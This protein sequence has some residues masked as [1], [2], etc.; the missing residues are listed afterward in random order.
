MVF[1]HTGFFYEMVFNEAANNMQKIDMK[2]KV[3]LSS[4]ILVIY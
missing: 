1:Y 4:K 2:I 3:Y